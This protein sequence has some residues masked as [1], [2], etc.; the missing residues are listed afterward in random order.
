[1]TRRVGYPA[2][3]DGPNATPLRVYDEGRSYSSVPVDHDA[4]GVRFHPARAAR[5]GP[6]PPRA[7]R[8]VAGRAPERTERRLA[9]RVPGRLGVD[10][11]RN[12]GAAVADHGASRDKKPQ[13][14]PPETVALYPQTWQTNSRRVPI[15]SLQPL[16]RRWYEPSLPGD[17][18]APG[19][20]APWVRPRSAGH[21]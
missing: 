19:T 13:S 20:A 4:A 15:R 10:D 14:S 16:S 7:D 11:V 5:T 2:I 3:R 12:E 17:G 18:R 8:A 9:R 6:V 1:M 21:Q